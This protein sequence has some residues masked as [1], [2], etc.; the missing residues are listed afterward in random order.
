MLIQTPILAYW[1]FVGDDKRIFLCCFYS[2]ESNSVTQCNFT[3]V[4][5]FCFYD[6]SRW[7]T[8]LVLAEEQ[9]LMFLY[10]RCQDA[11]WL[12]NVAVWYEVLHFW[13]LRL[14]TAA[15]ISLRCYSQPALTPWEEGSLSKERRVMFTLSAFYT[16]LTHVAVIQLHYG[17]RS[18]S[19]C[20]V[21]F[22]PGPKNPSPC[23]WGL[24]RRQ[25][26]EPWLVSAYTSGHFTVSNSPELQ[27]CGMQ[28]GSGAAGGNWCGHSG[29]YCFLYKDAHRYAASD[30]PKTWIWLFK[31]RKC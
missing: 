24:N 4:R 13:C 3:L 14:E 21:L 22:G 2:T 1:R 17:C 31:E 19:W 7:I 12:K 11:C 5:T 26:S 23:H 20:Q 30:G 29:A 15:R 27:V 6:P 28:E 9:A 18:S 16:G 10:D 8:Y 25:A